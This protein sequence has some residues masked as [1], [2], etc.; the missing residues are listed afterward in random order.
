MSGNTHS[1]ACHIPEDW[2]LQI[3]IHYLQCVK[4]HTYTGAA[5]LFL[6]IK[7]LLC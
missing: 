4:T 7:K 2:I 1:V 6:S 3:F 5:S